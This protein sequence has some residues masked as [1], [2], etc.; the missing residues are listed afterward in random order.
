MQNAQQYFRRSRTIR[1]SES[2]SFIRRITLLDASSCS[3]AVAALPLSTSILGFGQR[4]QR[5]SDAKHLLGPFQYRRNPSCSEIWV[6]GSVCTWESL[7][8]AAI[9]SMRA[10]VI[11]NFVITLEASHAAVRENP[12]F[13]RVHGLH[14]LHT[15]LRPPRES[16][17]PTCSKEDLL[18]RSEWL[19]PPVQIVCI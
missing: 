1:A 17:R 15:Y 8:S 7:P 6:P 18:W 14:C 12:H 10:T 16:N 9:S 2:S 5:I 13:R 19:P 4:D 3:R 11:L